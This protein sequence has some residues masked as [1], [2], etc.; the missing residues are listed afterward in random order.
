MQNHNAAVLLHDKNIRNNRILHHKVPVVQYTTIYDV[1]NN[2]TEAPKNN[3]AQ[4]YTTKAPEYCTTKAPEYC[5]TSYAAQPLTTRLL[6]T[7]PF[8]AITPML[9]LITLPKRSNATL[10]RPSYFSAQN[11]HTA[12]APSYY[13]EPK[14]YTEVPVCYTTTHA[15]LSYHTDAPNYYNTKAPEYYITT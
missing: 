9:Q 7:T 11:Y 2:Y 1:L 5:T 6:S 15:A 10:K 3:S 14:Y 4:S 13:V 8:Q 12:A